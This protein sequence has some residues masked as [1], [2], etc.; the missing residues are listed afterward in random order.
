[1]VQW[2]ST[3]VQHIV[4]G[5]L[6]AIQNLL[7]D[8]NQSGVEYLGGTVGSSDGFWISAWDVISGS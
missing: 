3:D 8:K 1:M 6:C 4:P 7:K 2:W 5:G